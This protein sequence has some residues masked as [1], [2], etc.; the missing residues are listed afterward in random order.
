MAE[1]DFDD[2]YDADDDEDLADFEASSVVADNLEEVMEMGNKKRKLT[3]AR[4]RIEDYMERRR[5]RDEMGDLDFDID[6]FDIA[7]FDID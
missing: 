4:N 5:L 1:D 7:D 6:D 3:S 2:E